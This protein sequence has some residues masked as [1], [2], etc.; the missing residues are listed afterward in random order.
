LLQVAQAR[1]DLALA[2][3]TLQRSAGLF[4][5]RTDRP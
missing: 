2:Y 5:A 3:L 1:F 4:L